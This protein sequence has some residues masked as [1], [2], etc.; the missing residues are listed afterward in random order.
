M[1]E[2]SRTIHSARPVP[3]EEY[4]R[5]GGGGGGARGP[6]EGRAVF[7]ARSRLKVPVLGFCEVRCGD[8][9]LPFGF[10]RLYLTGPRAA[11]GTPL[12]ERPQL[13]NL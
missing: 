13:L 3:L 4:T 11:L 1:P 12:Q 9:L 8:F 10:L 5:P 2:T 6:A 7:G